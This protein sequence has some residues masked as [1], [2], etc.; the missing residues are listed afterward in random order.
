MQRAGRHSLKTGPGSEDLR[1]R[2]AKQGHRGET[3]RRRED[4]KMQRRKEE[5][6]ITQKHTWRWILA[7]GEELLRKAMKGTF[8]LHLLVFHVYNGLRTVS[9]SDQCYSMQC[10]ALLYL[11]LE[12]LPV[13]F[14]F[15]YAAS[16][17]E[18]DPSS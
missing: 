5:K 4:R 8:W 17:N 9:G 14:R 18:T 13:V 7:I 12:K 16:T 1:Q 6:G 11:R 10:Q 2:A 15:G 3:R